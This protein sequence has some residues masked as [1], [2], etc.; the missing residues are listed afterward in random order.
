MSLFSDVCIMCVCVCVC[1]CLCVCLCA[2]VCVCVCERERERERE[3]EDDELENSVV[4]ICA[5]IGCMILWWL[6]SQVRLKPGEERAQL[7]WKL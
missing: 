2:S 3:R 1:V 5:V 6:C 4:M 7:R